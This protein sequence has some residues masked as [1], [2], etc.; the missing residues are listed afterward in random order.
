MSVMLAQS[1]DFGKDELHPPPTQPPEGQREINFTNQKLLSNQLRIIKFLVLATF[2]P[3]LCE[4][5]HQCLSE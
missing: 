3:L 5:L 4:D 2:S 1:S